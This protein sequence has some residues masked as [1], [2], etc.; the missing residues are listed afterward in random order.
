[1]K[2]TG[3][4]LT[5]SLSRIYSPLAI[6]GFTTVTNEECRRILG[7]DKAAFIFDSKVCVLPV[8]DRVICDSDNGAPLIVDNKIIGI[9]SWNIP[10]DHNSLI[11]VERIAAHFEF[12]QQF[13]GPFE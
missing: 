6:V 8:D 10:C 1:M 11:V 7:G 3:F 2:I 13:I 9:S 12:I 4:G 5:E